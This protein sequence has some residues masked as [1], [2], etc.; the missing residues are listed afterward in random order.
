MNEHGGLGKCGSM[1]Y[2]EA[3]DQES[4]QHV[5]SVVRPSTS[6]TRLRHAPSAARRNV[7]PA[8]RRVA[9]R[10]MFRRFQTTSSSSSPPSYGTPHVAAGV[11][12]GAVV[13]LGGYAWYHISGAKK[14]VDASRTASAYY[15]QTKDAIASKAPKNPNE[16]LDQLRHFAHSYLVI[17]P[18][19]RPHVDA[20]FDTIDEL[21]DSHGDDVNRIVSDGYEEIRTIIRDSS[22]LDATAAMKVFDVFRKRSAELEELGKGIGKDVFGSLSER[23]P[24][25]SDKLGG[26]YD[27][28]QKLVKTRGPEAKKIYDETTQQV[29]IND[30]FSKGFS[31]DSIDQARKLI[32]GKTEELRNFAQSSSKDAWDRALKDA[33][34]YLDKVPEIKQFLNENA[35]KFIAA[36]AAT[37]SSSGSGTQEL[38]ARIK[39]AAQGGD[40]SKNKDKTNELRDFVHAKAREA[41]EEGSRQLE[42]GWESMQ[43]W[44]RTMPGGED[45]LKRIPD[46]KV[47]VQVSR[48]RSED[49]QKLVKETYEAVLQVLE[50]KG[51]KA[52]KMCEDVKEDGKKAS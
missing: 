24:Q 32:Q 47:F 37:L 23:Y 52:R 25:L 38:F 6:V 15:Q 12:G 46:V 19:A 1:G 26:G 4:L 50:E 36:G 18:G 20:A 9:G 30:I 7:P 2:F 33:S 43:G 42:Q 45:A 51:K 41:E 48:E 5:S 16:A 13:L 44:I 8:A 14:A 31:Q 28:F 35:D 29:R 17:I 49:A 27:E 3:A 34:P 10:N 11:A 21:R 22:S 39:D 40:L